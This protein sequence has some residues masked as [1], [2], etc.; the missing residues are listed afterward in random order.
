MWVD[1][2]QNTD[3]WDSLRLKRLTSSTWAKI[4]ANYGKSFGD[5]AKKEAERI[6]LEMVTG[7]KDETEVY[8]SGYMQM[9]HDF[10]DEA[11]LLYEQE[12][13]KI[14]SKGG[15]F[16]N[17]EDDRIGDS[18]DRNVGSDGVLEIKSVIPKTQ[19]KRLK[20]GGFDTAYTWQ[21]HSHIWTGNKEWCD[22]ASYCVSMPEN[23]RLYVHRIYR[24]EEIINKM[25]IRKEEFFIEVDKNVEIL[26]R[27]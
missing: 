1:V 12:Q 26:N 5:P 4:M 8:K 23:K 15:F 18:P 3:E 25:R 7:K 17:D 13:F 6:A 16:L 22:F 27:Y 21:I 24:D 20:K 2:N 9:G 11:W 14:T 10:E 19:F